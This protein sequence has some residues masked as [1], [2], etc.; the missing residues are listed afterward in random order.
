VLGHTLGLPVTKVDG[1]LNSFES[2]SVEH[3]EKIYATLRECREQCGLQLK[4]AIKMQ[5]W[6]NKRIEKTKKWKC[7]YF[8]LQKVEGGEMRLYYYENPKRMKPKGIIDLNF[9]YLYQVN[10]IFHFV[11]IS[12]S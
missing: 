7:L 5:G 1:D 10:F 2:K 9:S 4:K 3:A 6:L 11:V 8:I 12:G